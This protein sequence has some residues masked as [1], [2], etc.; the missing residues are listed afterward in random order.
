MSRKSIWAREETALAAVDAVV[1]RSHP[2]ESFVWK[3]RGPRGAVMR[4]KGED[5]AAAAS[6]AAPLGHAQKG[7]APRCGRGGLVLPGTHDSGDL[8]GGCDDR[9]SRSRERT[10]VFHLEPRRRAVSFGLA[11]QVAH[12]LVVNLDHRDPK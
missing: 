1:R 2:R 11:E 9:L 4:G 8:I 12:Y 7:R 3:P 10:A 5:L 6:R